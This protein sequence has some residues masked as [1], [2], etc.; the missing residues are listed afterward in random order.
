METITC[1]CGKTSQTFKV[2]TQKDFPKGWETDCCVEAAQKAFMDEMVAEGL[3][4]EIE[5]EKQYFRKITEDGP[6]NIEVESEEHLEQLRAEEVVLAEVL[7]ALPTTDELPDLTPEDVQ[8]IAEKVAD[9]AISDELV[10]AQL[11][12]P[13]TAEVKMTNR[14]KK[15]AKKAAAAAK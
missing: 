13:R 14:E 5:E 9:M 8:D 11:E 4:V 2:L 6:V 12:A 7:A 1:I 10:A 3:A 15:A